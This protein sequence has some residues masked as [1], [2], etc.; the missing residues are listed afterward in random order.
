MLIRQISIDGYQ[1]IE[2]M[3]RPLKQLAILEPRPT[4]VRDR[5][6]FMALDMSR[7]APID[8]FIEENLHLRS[9]CDDL[10]HGF[11]KKRDHLLSRDGGEALEKI[12]DRLPPFEIVDERL[13]RNSG[14]SEHWS[15]T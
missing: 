11:V 7:E 10:F 14:P 13:H 12:I 6:Y 9:L 8:A 1:N 15:S 3:L 4:S 5:L 2:F